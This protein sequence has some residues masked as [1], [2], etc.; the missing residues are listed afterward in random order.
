MKKL[1]GSKSGRGESRKSI[2]MN[3]GIEFEK[4][5]RIFLEARDRMD[6]KISEV[7]TSATEI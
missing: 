2:E 4:C 6:D 7:H 5:S 3:L 1:P